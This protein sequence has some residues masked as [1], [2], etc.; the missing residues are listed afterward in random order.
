MASIDTNILV[1]WITR[2]DAQ[3]VTA[4]ENLLHAATQPCSVSVLVLAEAE[5]VL[6]SYY[7]FPRQL[8]AEHYSAILTSGLF[9]ADEQL[10]TVALV[11]Y[12]AH[13]KL[14]LVDCLLESEA[15]RSGKAP[16][17]TFDKK[18]ANQLPGAELL[19]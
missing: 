9:D 1:R 13:P 16:L 8:I 4:L 17:Y 7:G 14:S 6:R 19:A 3:E 15:S 5:H 18:L 11:K 2:D 12:Q 10:L